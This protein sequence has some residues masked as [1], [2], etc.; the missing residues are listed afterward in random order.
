VRSA[1]IG[2]YQFGATGNSQSGVYPIWNVPGG[3]TLFCILD[4]INYGNSLDLGDFTAGDP[5][6]PQTL[7]T[8]IGIISDNTVVEY[9]T[10]DVTPSV[11]Q[12]IADERIYNQ[13]RMR[14]PVDLD[15]D[16]LGDQLEFDS[17][18][19]PLSTKPYLII[20]YDSLTAIDSPV[21]LP[22]AFEIF[23]N[24]PNPFNAVTNIRY[25]LNKG[26]IVRLD[27]YDIAGRL[28]ENLINSYNPAGEHVLTID[29]GDLPSGVYYYRMKLGRQAITKKMLLIR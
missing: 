26:G 9:K 4:H 10:M 12:D 1:T 7:H 25:R 24:Y 18:D 20:N 3:D 22:Q 6:D 21:A 29:A 15:Y 13:Y 17:G 8:N 5:G 14:F 16:S 23:Q 19:V 2:I 28:V 11:K 27:L